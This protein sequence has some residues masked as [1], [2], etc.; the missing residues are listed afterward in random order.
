MSCRLTHAIATT[1][2]L[3]RLV[4]PSNLVYLLTDLQLVVTVWRQDSLQRNEIS[5]ECVVVVVAMKRRHAVQ[6]TAAAV[7]RCPHLVRWCVPTNGFDGAP[8]PTANTPPASC[9]YVLFLHGAVSSPLHP[10]TL[11]VTAC[12]PVCCTRVLFIYCRVRLHPR[13]DITRCSY[14]RDSPVAAR[15]LMGARARS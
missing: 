9:V 1:T 10:R 12:L 3:A 5:G 8:Q 14:T 11:T 15:G 4:Q 7:S 6:A 13:P 2:M